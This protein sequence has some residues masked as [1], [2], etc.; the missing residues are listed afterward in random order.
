MKLARLRREAAAEITKVDDRVRRFRVSDGSVDRYN[1][2]ISVAGWELDNFRKNP[3]VLLQHG[4]T[5]D[6]IPVIGKALRVEQS[7]DALEAD[8][9]IFTTKEHPEADRVLALIDRGV[10]ATSVGFNP[11]E[12]EYAQERETGDEYQD[13]WNPPTDYLRQELLEI[14]VVY[15]PG[16]ANAVAEGRQLA[17]D[18][19]DL[20]LRMAS[21]ELARPVMRNLPARRPAPQVKAP[22]PTAPERAKAPERAEPPPPPPAPLARRVVK[23]PENFAELV[24]SATADEVRAALARRRGRLTP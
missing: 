12:S 7:G 8:I 15:L 14:S 21:Q 17:G 13:Y 5:S 11:L 9:E 3:V 4:Y 6:D 2:T 20:V 19:A 24:R 23:V 18:E 22:A 16:N 1:S 10:L